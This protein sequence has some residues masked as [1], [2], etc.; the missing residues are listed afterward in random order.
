M[1]E[2][3]VICKQLM[4]SYMKLH[5]PKSLPHMAFSLPYRMFLLKCNI[6]HVKLQ[7]LTSVGLSQYLTLETIN[8][9]I[10]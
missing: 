1:K 10:H 3:E 5:E 8:L 7:I 4:T 9:D 2:E 6:E